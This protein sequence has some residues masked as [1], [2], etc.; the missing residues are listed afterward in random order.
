MCPGGPPDQTEAAQSAGSSL[1][2]ACTKSREYLEQK[3]ARCQAAGVRRACH[4]GHR[5]TWR[6]AGWGDVYFGGGCLLLL[7]EH[8]W[9][10][11]GVPI[12]RIRSFF[13][14]ALV[15]NCRSP[16]PA[17]LLTAIGKVADIRS[18]C[19]CAGVLECLSCPKH[20]LPADLK[21]GCQET[22]FI[23]RT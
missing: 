6:R 18:N 19:T 1:A 3:S 12:S 8:H 15:P 11:G 10:A 16:D 7:V 14:F 21:L 5:H 9:A 22:N 23:E 4:P 20:R 17:P 2:S 13:T